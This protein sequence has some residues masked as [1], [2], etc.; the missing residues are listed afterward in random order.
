MSSL[1]RI[2][3]SRANGARSRGPVTLEGNRRSSRNAL[4]HGLL[5]RC[6][7]MQGESPKALQALLNEHLDRLEPADGVEFGMV[8]EMVAAYWRLCRAWAIETR[9]FDNQVAAQPAGGELD[10]MT[11]AF[12]DLAAKPT[13]ALLHRYETRLHLIYHRALQSL[14][15]LR[16]ARPN[17]PRKLLK[18]ID[19]TLEPPPEVIAESAVDRSRRPAP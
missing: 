4:A 13:A 16:L 9:T 17:E 15:L 11:S 5:A 8:Q 12:A 1:K 7:L 2:L 18:T 19:R 3:T 14:L 6:T 10:R